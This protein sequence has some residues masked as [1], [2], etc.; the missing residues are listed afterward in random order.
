MST[1]IFSMSLAMGPTVTRVGAPAQ[2]GRDG[3]LAGT[4]QGAAHRR[5]EPAR[6]LAEARLRRRSAGEPNKVK[7]IATATVNGR[8]VRDQDSF[9]FRR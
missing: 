3:A 8:K 2:R 4:Q 6:M 1:I 9:K 7:L 5:A